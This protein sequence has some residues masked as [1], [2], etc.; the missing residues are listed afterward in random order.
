MNKNVSSGRVPEEADPFLPTTTNPPRQGNPAGL[1]DGPLRH[2][3][4]AT[5]RNH[6]D[7]KLLNPEDREESRLRVTRIPA[8]GGARAPDMIG[9]GGDRGLLDTWRAVGVGGELFF[10][11]KFATTN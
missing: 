11:T 10:I 8:R 5:D 7:M 9:I 3:V 1:Q 2:L 6:R 4:T